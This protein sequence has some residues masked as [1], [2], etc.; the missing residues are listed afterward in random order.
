MTDPYALL[1]LGV[2]FSVGLAADQL[3]RRTRIPRVTLLLVC[4]LAVGTMGLLPDRVAELTDT[5]TITALTLIALLLSGSMKLETRKAHGVETITI[6]LAIV[7]TTLLV[8][9]V[10]LT[11]LGV[12]FVLALVLASIATATAPAATRDVIRQSRVKNS[13]T[14]IVI[15]IVAIDD[16]W[17]LFVFSFCPAVA[18]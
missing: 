13:F 16:A 15:G 3:G 2:L 9:T 5:V 11:L 12:D 14:D 1:T 10:G 4:G 6:S 17:G 18:S 7:I 8:V